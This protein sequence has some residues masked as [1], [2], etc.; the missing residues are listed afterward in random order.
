MDSLRIHNQNMH[1]WLNRIHNSSMRQMASNGLKRIV[2]SP[3]GWLGNDLKVL[4][5]ANSVNAFL[6]LSIASNGDMFEAMSYRGN[7]MMNVIAEPFQ[8]P[9][10]NRLFKVHSRSLDLALSLDRV[11]VSDGF[12][13]LYPRVVQ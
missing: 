10:L 2:K 5:P 1:R 4:T 12:V 9:A 13:V 7:G 11:E 6:P 8:K 3:T